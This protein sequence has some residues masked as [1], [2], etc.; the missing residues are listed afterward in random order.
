MMS[1]HGSRQMV[2]V[3]VAACT[4][5]TVASLATLTVQQARADAP[6]PQPAVYVGER[7]VCRPADAS[8]AANAVMASGTQQLHCRPINVTLT[9]SS[10]R[11]YVIGKPQTDASGGEERVSVTS[12]A[13]TGGVTGKGLNDSWIDMVKKGLAVGETSSNGVV[14]VG[15]RWVCRPA[16]ADHPSNASMPSAGAA[17]PLSC[18]AVNFSMQT[19]SGQL[20]VIGH[21]Q[22]KAKPSVSAKDD[23][24]E[25]TAPM[26]AP[27][28]ASGLTVE[29]MNDSWN[30]YVNRVFDIATS[31]AGGG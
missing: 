22:A 14:N 28:Y 13:Y 6:S 18:R 20:I 5:T 12:P 27:S 29:Q 24:K 19:S 8:N 23:T 1:R 30:A 10:G 7:W 15:D 25:Q 9:T 17:V 11:V 26:S 4:F 3:L 31:A 16:D 2:P 21:A